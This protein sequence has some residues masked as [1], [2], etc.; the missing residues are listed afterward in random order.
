LF[1][2][3]KRVITKAF[4]VRVEVDAPLLLDGSAEDSRI[5]DLKE[6]LDDTTSNE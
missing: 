4:Q 6:S 5:L 2:V 3:K 1:K